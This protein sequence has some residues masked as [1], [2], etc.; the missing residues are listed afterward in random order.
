MSLKEGKWFLYKDNWE[1]IILMLLSTYPILKLSFISVLIMILMGYVILFKRIFILNNLKKHS[2]K[3][4]LIISGW[5]LFMIFTLSYSNN[6]L[7]GFREIIKGISFIL[8]PT[9]LIYG[10]NKIDNKK[11]KYFFYTLT[12]SNIFF[13]FYLYYL[14]LFA[15]NHFLYDGKLNYFNFLKNIKVFSNYTSYD[16]LDYIRWSP[17]KPF[18]EI[19]RTY[20][21]FS[22]L[23]CLM[24]WLDLLM[25]NK[26]SIKTRLQA[27]FFIF[28]FGFF[29]FYFF[30]IINCILLVLLTSIFLFLSYRKASFT[31]KTI[32]IALILSI[33]GTIG[34]T[35]STYIKSQIAKSQLYFSELH[36]IDSNGNLEIKEGRIR[37]A[38]VGFKLFKEKPILGYGV[39]DV[40]E[41]QLEEYK[42]RG[43]E[44][45][46]SEKHNTHNYYLNLLLIGGIPLLIM[47]IILIGYLFYLSIKSND[48]LFLSLTLIISFNLLTENF[49][50]RIYGIFAFS[51][52]L[53][54]FFNPII[55]D[56]DKLKKKF[57]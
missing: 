14:A 49:L 8:I 46:Y 29:I 32:A 57:K 12:I 3:P 51:L 6:K 10:F 41:H 5:Y 43:Y 11:R 44:V 47:F 24:F 18:L 52:F 37:L 21:C 40:Q 15:F 23:M 31:K 4:L 19:H 39:G 7:Y 26:N 34:Y 48:F 28:F 50:S 55:S 9:A 20:F 16:F 42:A 53:C 2:L 13:L 36:L 17:K 56:H 1:I 33:I 22:F 25:F 35:N 27:L 45:E 30:S 38:N 54:V